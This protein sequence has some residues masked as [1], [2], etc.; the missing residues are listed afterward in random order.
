MIQEYRCPKCSLESHIYFRPDDKS[1]KVMVDIMEDHR[2][3]SP[4]CSVTEFKDLIILP[5]IRERD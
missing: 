2:K 3:W 1:Y 4:E 5:S